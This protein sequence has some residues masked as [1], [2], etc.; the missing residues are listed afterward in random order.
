MAPHGSEF[1]FRACNR[2]R[3]VPPRQRFV[4][5]VPC[6]RQPSRD[7]ATTPPPPRQDSNTIEFSHC[8]SRCDLDACLQQLSLSVRDKACDRARHTRDNSRDCSSQQV[9][10][11]RTTLNE[12][13]R[14]YIYRVQGLRLSSKIPAVP[15]P[16]I[17]N[18][19]P[20]P[21]PFTLNPY[22]TQLRKLGSK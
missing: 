14:V 13:P 11:R 12:K 10:I 15:K 3:G 4:T 20:K 9:P 22:K 2:H 1:F 19:N 6:P 5:D 21:K 16:F 17:R 7:K 8:Q 18:P